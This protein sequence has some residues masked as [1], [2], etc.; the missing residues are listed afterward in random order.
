M[1][2]AFSVAVK[3]SL[4]N[5]V[6]GGLM[7]MSRQFAKVHG[8]VDG[9]QRK[10][11]RIKATMLVGGGLTAAGLGIFGLLGKTLP[12]TME[13]SRQLNIMNRA[14]LSQVEIAQAIGAAWRNTGTVMTTTATENLR[15]LLDLRN[16]LGNMREAQFALPIVSKIGT[17]M[18]LSSGGKLDAKGGEDIAFAMAKALDIIGAAKDE[19]TFVHEAGLMSKV[20]TAFQ[21]RVT[22]QQYQGVFQYARQAKFDLSD[23][24]KY[25]FLPAM[26]LEMSSGAKSAGGGSRG[27]GPTLAALYRFTN[28]GYVNK[29]SIPLID[30][31]GLLTSHDFTPTTTTGTVGAKLKGAELAAQN[32]F[33][34]NQQVLVPAIRQYLGPKATDQQIRAVINEVFRGNQLAASQMVEYFT[35]PQNFLRDQKVIQGALPYDKA[36]ADA[37]KNDPAFAMLQMQAQW[38]NFLTTMGPTVLAD[39]ISIANRIAPLLHDMAMWG[40]KN[41][42]G[43]RKF[44]R[45]MET[46]GAVLMFGGGALMIKGTADA[47]GIMFK[48]I[49]GAVKVANAPLMFQVAKG[50]YAIG[51]SGPTAATGIAAVGSGLLGVVA[52]IS[53]AV[54][55]AL[56]ALAV[57]MS[58]AKSLQLNRVLKDPN[59]AS[60]EDLIE[61]AQTVKARASSFAADAKGHHIADNASTR[62]LAGRY[63]KNANALKAEAAKRLKEANGGVSSPVVAPATVQKQSFTGD[64]HMDGAKVGKVVWRRQADEL[65]RDSRRGRTSVDPG[66][67]LVP[68]G[69][70]YT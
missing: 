32:P 14:G 68:V 45:S 25:E 6:A 33:T 34:W 5:G 65:E 4:I 13:Y 17:V 59:S 16:V 20:I 12:A 10:L 2:E 36:F 44:I 48:V 22:P 46:L 31:L 37:A 47:L 63:A 28:Q 69:L 8:D 9:L 55:P 60:T 66:M 29:K 30:R 38:Q 52:V 64:V 50:L 26:M 57:G 7:A 49:G 15:A 1:F 62:A 43:I 24:F 70:G 23:E 3:V 19:K 41:P 58:I 18:S 42:D 39:L 61:A 54:I 67:A 11:D 40:Q 21:G 51:A 53:N 27:I 35:K 56:A